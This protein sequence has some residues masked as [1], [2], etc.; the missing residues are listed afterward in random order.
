[1]FQIVS[2]VFLAAQKHV[3]HDCEVQGDF[4]SDIAVFMSD[5]VQCLALISSLATILEQFTFFL[6]CKRKFPDEKVA[7]SQVREELLLSKLSSKSN[8]IIK[9]DR[10][11]PYWVFW[12]VARLAHALL[13]F[14]FS[15]AQTLKNFINFPSTMLF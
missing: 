10:A 9:A 14:Y 6:L 12:T 13:K 5:I 7:L 11:L 1:M 2:N 4:A 3:S 8:L 15:L